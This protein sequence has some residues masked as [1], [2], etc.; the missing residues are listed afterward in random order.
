MEEKITEQELHEYAQNLLK[1]G[2][3]T[4][5][6]VVPE[7]N[8][9][10]L[11]EGINSYTLVYGESVEATLNPTISTTQLE[12]LEKKPELF[13]NLNRRYFFDNE[14]SSVFSDEKTG[15]LIRAASK[16]LERMPKC[17]EKVEIQKKIM[18]KVNGIKQEVKEIE[19]FNKN[20]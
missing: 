5:I 7:F 3:Y 16:G 6:D 9:I 4:H 8:I 15:K 12:M 1:T 19:K 10:E 11:Y 14:N 17:S 13:M 2:R 20:N 18:A